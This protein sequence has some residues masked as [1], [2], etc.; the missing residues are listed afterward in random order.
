MIKITI[1]FKVKN[2]R[3]SRSIANA[4]Q[5]DNLSAPPSVKI[6]TKTERNIVR[7]IVSSKNP[8]T[9]LATIDD[10]LVC[11]DAAYKTLEGVETAKRP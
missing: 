11:M 5:P 8:E 7:S 6:K 2:S 9:L 3:I 10:L 4:I 1:N